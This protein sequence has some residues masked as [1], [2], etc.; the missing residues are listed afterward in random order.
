M[1][2]DYPG[3]SAS[4]RRLLLNHLARPPGWSP[5]TARGLVC[6][7]CCLQSVIRLALEMRPGWPEPPH[8]LQTAAH[9]PIMHSYAIIHL[10]ITTLGIQAS[11]PTSPHRSPRSHVNVVSNKHSQSASGPSGIVTTPC[12]PVVAYGKAS[13]VALAR[14]RPLTDH[15]LTPSISLP[16]R[17]LSILPSLY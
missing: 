12:S 5:I 16:G 15:D 11:P 2:R 6:C 4:V 10:L 13:Q 14:P 8:P 1:H 3:L 17:F 9:P 7:L